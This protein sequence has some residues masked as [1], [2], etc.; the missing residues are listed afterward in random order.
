MNG[1]RRYFNKINRDALKGLAPSGAD[2]KGDDAQPHGPAK[3]GHQLLS[4]PLAGAG[5]RVPGCRPCADHLLRT[6]DKGRQP[7]AAEGKDRARG[8]EQG[9]GAD[10]A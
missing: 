9:A 5:R 6:Q 3:A 8:Q 4:D 7:E 10:E 1:F 2:Q